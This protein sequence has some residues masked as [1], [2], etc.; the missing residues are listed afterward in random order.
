[1][2]NRDYWQKRFV[3]LEESQINKGTAY[4]HE[5][6]KQYRKAASEI[7]KELSKWY[8]RLAVN[9]ELSIAEAKKLLDR[10]ELQEFH[11]SVEEYI[12]KGRTLNISD[13]WAKHL[14]NA[15]AKVHIS[16]YEALKLQMQQ[17][18]E[19]LYGNELD[20]MDK[21]M[22]DIYT[23]TY[24]RTAFEI[25]K[26]LGV[27]SDFMRLDDKK[28]RQIIA[29]PWA[30][31]GSN[32]SSRI[33]KQK[34]QL[35]TELQNQI[36]QD[37]VLGRSPRESIKAIKDKFNVSSGQAGR[38]VM[39]ETSFFHSAAQKD[40]FNKLNVEEYEIV[41]TLDNKT[42]EICQNMDGKHM[43][44]SEFKPGIT[45]PPFH[46]W[47]RST[48]VPYFDDEFTV[49]ETRA[50]RSEETGKYYEVPANMTYP[51]WEKAFVDGDKAGLKEVDGFKEESHRTKRSGKK[52]HGVAWN[53]VKT[54]QYT[55]R[56]NEISDNK[57]ANELAAKHARNMLANRDGMKSEEIYAISL[58]TGKD[59]SSITDQ[60]N[61]Y[62]VVRT[63]KFTNRVNEA[64]ER[65]EKILYLHNHPR[66]L[67]PSI[68]DLNEMVGELNSVGLIIGHN[69]NIYLYTAPDKEIT[70]SD[71]RIANKK[72]IEY[73]YELE[74]DEKFIEVLSEQMNFIFRKL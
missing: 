18:I 24:Y 20:S 38:L 46:C 30:A 11:W 45:A 7:E 19:V 21:F 31:D 66:G 57:Q 10:D 42:S 9:N 64:L 32:F 36:T 33:W 67:P 4:Y 56:F 72:M 65:G 52:E 59:I 71:I 29:K 3:L 55:N 62:G 22:K 58:T 68:T 51:E 61:D 5:L 73:N 1:M 25:Q 54:K 44:M 50:A 6:E 28:V 13:Q 23:D 47:C 69:G 37:M 70:D 40:T 2:A 26:G 35:V 43:P 16:R 41:A 12:E 34:A 8:A 60:F 53:Q 14:E 27:G 49:G 15:S 17:Q 74:D 63:E 48:T 39:T